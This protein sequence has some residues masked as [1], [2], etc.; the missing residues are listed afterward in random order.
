MWNDTKSKKGCLSPGQNLK[1]VEGMEDI[2]DLTISLDM[3]VE[4][5]EFLGIDQIQ[6][7]FKI[8]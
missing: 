1:I 6:T 3:L 2:L 8:F 7:S 4:K 5:Y